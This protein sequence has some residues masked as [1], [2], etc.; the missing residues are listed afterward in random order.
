[1]RNEPTRIRVLLRLALTIAMALAP[2]C[3]AAQEP[4][5][6]LFLQAL[7]APFDTL[8]PGSIQT[9]PFR[10]ENRGDST[11]SVTDRL[12]APH[13]WNV[14]T[15]TPGLTLKPGESVTRLVSVSLSA[16]AEEGFHEIRYTV[17]PVGME[18]SVTLP[19]MP[20]G[21]TVYRIS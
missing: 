11:V 15:G 12:D 21:M 8:R 16:T 9:L 6:R 13:G 14:V 2:I 4:E 10:I 1:M 19:A 18:G 20:A 3:A 17:I 7:V 5:A